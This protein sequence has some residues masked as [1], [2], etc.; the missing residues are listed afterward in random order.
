M[1]DSN[2]SAEQDHQCTCFHIDSRLDLP[3]MVGGLSGPYDTGF[4]LCRDFDEHT[5]S[6]AKSVK[7][8]QNLADSYDKA[9]TEVGSNCFGCLSYVCSTLH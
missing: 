3:C 2:V 4:L 5:K 8:M 1:S 7:E 6:N 9:V